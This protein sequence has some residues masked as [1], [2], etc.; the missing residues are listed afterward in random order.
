MKLGLNELSSKQGPVRSSPLLPRLRDRMQFTSKRK[1]V[2]SKIPRREFLK[3][4]GAAG[5]GLAVWPLV[6][7]P[8][9]PAGV[10]LSR[11]NILVFLTDD[12][13]QWAQHAYGNSELKTPNMDRLAARGVRMTQ[14]FTTC[15]VCSPARSSFFTGRMP[16]Q[17]GIHDWLEEKQYALTHP[18]LTGQ[19]LISE[20]M[21]AAGYHTGLIGKWH[22]GRTQ[23]PK[24]GFDRWFSY[25]VDQYPHD[26]VQ[27][28]SDQGKL[29]VEDG[30]QSPFFTR[31]AIDFLQEQ[32]RNGGPD[33]KPF[34]LFIGYVD[35]HGPHDAAP[36]DLVAEYGQATFRD[37]RNEKFPPCHGL[38][39]APVDP[40]PDKERRKR[41]EYYGAV[42]SLD[43][44][45]GKVLD[46]LEATG[47]MDN[48]LIVYTG[49]HGLNTGQHGMWEKGNATQP[50]N[51]LEESIRISCT[52]SWPAGGIRQNA[53][54]DDFVG[55]P[56][57]WATLLEIAGATPD[58]ATAAKINSP[59]VSYLR[60]LRGQKVARW[61]RT[62]I[63]EYGNARMARTDRY[64]LIKRY[65]FGGV[66]FPD[67]LYDLK[68]DPRETVNCHGNP[69]HK[70]VVDELSA[71]I[72][73]FFAKYMA[74]GHSGLDMEHQPECTPAS[75][76]LVAARDHQQHDPALENMQRTLENLAESK[77]SI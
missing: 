69:L 1:G 74:P 38:A 10:R 23:E 62:A 19:T 27:H 68:E 75:P 70:G 5:T 76:W 64:K 57:L 66:T 52:L 34:F 47:Q 11:P 37:I 29:T 54:C 71:E 17:H 73:R 26:G 61:R 28:F 25:W 46:E 16:S 39:R 41:M 77:H 3:L 30:Q 43:R 51:F 21:K 12:H 31:R 14:S 60:Q 44:E 40:D 50:Q 45:V 72:D 15:P 8:A 13:G 53:T 67:E 20:L 58:A 48:T 56:D 42:A 65:P 32:K 59:G 35:T 36:K 49:D 7:P 63:C 9:A 6:R 18:G 2:M 55:H 24:P 33:G 22:C 4:P